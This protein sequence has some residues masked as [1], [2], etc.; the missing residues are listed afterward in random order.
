MRPEILLDAITWQPR[1]DLAPLDIDLTKFFHTVL[2]G[3][4][5]DT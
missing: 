1:P 5:L 2:T 4:Q 3:V